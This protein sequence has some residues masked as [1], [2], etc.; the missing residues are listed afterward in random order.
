MSDNLEYEDGGHGRF[1]L[2]DA[3]R[4]YIRGLHPWDRYFLYHDA[5]RQL[6]HA[7]PPNDA[8]L[9][10]PIIAAKGYQV[11]PELLGHDDTKILRDLLDERIDGQPVDL[12]GEPQWAAPL[13]WT[14]I[15]IQTVREILQRMLAG[16]L[17]DVLRGYFG[18]FYRIFS[19]SVTRAFPAK[20]EGSFRWHRDVEPPQQTHLM[21]YLTDSSDESGSTSFLD[22]EQTRSAAQAGY[23]FPSDGQRTGNLGEIADLA[24]VELRAEQPSLNAGD[25]G[26]FAASRILHKG[27]LPTAGNR[28]VMTLLFL[29]SSVPW[30]EYLKRDTAMTFV[31][32]HPGVSS[33]EPFENVAIVRPP[34]TDI[35]EWALRGDLFPPKYGA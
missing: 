14:M 12:D 34:L 35:P 2:S 21:I 24:G 6:Y 16:P 32:Q 8:A 3:S 18:C 28:D 10:E 11:I 19:L 27:N 26:L 33:V 7:N 1:I 15:R 4:E 31:G 22:L 13:P 5:C 29:P 30:D 20:A 9:S 23:H 25:G 17:N